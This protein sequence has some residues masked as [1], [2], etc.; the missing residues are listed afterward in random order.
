MRCGIRKSTFRIYR[1]RV[2][3]GIW[4]RSRRDILESK[5]TRFDPEKL[6]DEYEKAL[7]KLVQRKT[8]G[9]VIEA[10]EPEEKPSNVI[11]LM[12][13]LRES[14]RADRQGG[15]P[16]RESAKRGNAK[17]RKFAPS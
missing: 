15:H 17:P 1:R 7:R 2:S 12:D 14:V 3:A 13:A 10:L 9:Q 5:A 4:F 6:K 11:N 16:G 8:K